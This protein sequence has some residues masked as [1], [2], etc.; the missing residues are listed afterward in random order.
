MKDEDAG[1]LCGLPPKPF[2]AIDRSPLPPW[3]FVPGPF[4]TESYRT[5]ERAGSVFRLQRRSSGS[6]N[7]LRTL[8]HRGVRKSLRPPALLRWTRRVRWIFAKGGRQ[9]D[10]VILLLDQDLA[11]LLGQGKLPEMFALSDPSAIVA[12]C[13]VFVV[14]VVAQHL[15][16]FLGGADRLW[17]STTGILPK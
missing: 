16:R 15:L 2:A 12:N 1:K 11:D 9:I 14:Q 6:S 17:Y 8:P 10:L 7:D 4:L 3:K 5:G 13:L